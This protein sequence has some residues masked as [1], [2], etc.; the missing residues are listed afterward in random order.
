[1]A[2]SSNSKVKEVQQQVDDVKAVMQEN[3]EVML[4]NIDKTEV[5]ENKS[6]ELANQAKTFHKSARDTRR[7][8]CKQNMKM[9]LIIAG[10]PAASAPDA[11]HATPARRRPPPAAT[12][13]RR[14][15]HRRQPC[16]LAGACII[17][18]LIIII[19]IVS[20]VGSAA[21]A[22]DT[23]DAVTS[24]PAPAPSSSPPDSSR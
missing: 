5:L 15:R 4:A 9:N 24:D 13:P 11:T 19:P 7:M 20:T 23:A 21:A 17:I 10:A 1:M 18:L 8:M 6:A 2:S 3:V 22:K 16:Y 12:A 14:A